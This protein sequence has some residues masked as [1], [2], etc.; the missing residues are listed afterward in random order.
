MFGSVY[1]LPAVECVFSVVPPSCCWKKSNGFVQKHVDTP[2]RAKISRCDSDG[3]ELDFV[4][5]EVFSN[6]YDF[7]SASHFHFQYIAQNA[8]CVS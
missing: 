6:L 8:K 1:S 2:L 3:L 7:K 4:V 5:L